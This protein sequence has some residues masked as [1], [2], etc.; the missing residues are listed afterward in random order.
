MTHSG[1]KPHAV[2]DRGQRYEVR[3]TGYPKDEQS[4][5]GW[6]D[7]GDGA[8][9]MA[10]AIRK[11]PGCVS[12]EVFDRAEN[13]LIAVMFTEQHCPGHVASMA[14]PKVCGKCGVHIDS[15]RPPE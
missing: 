1:G 12:T 4:V 13:R 11:A 9:R 3:A 15:L 10:S 14:D 7:R 8:A 2:G 6:T 5:I